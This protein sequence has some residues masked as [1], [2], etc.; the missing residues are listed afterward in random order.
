MGK[1]A[2]ES[3]RAFSKVLD[4][5]SAA[6]GYLHPANDQNCETFGSSSGTFDG[7]MVPTGQKA[8]RKALLDGNFARRKLPLRDREYC[9]WDSELPGFGCACGRQASTPGSFGFA[10]AASTDASPSA[11]PMNST[12]R[13]PDRR[14]AGS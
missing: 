10:I 12:L 14:R 13:W 7:L 8:F 3:V 4:S 2:L 6:D 9:I 1:S 11:V 5:A